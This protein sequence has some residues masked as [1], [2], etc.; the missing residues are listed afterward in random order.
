M[1][2]RGGD[3][4]EAIR[5]NETVNHL[6]YCSAIARVGCQ[7]IEDSLPCVAWFMTLSCRYAITKPQRA[8]SVAVTPNPI[9]S[10]PSMDTA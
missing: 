2:A 3:D 9:A 4:I 10:E 8:K 7:T 1:C 6:R 5:L